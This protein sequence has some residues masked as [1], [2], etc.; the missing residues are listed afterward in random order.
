MKTQNSFH[1]FAKGRKATNT[2][3][4]M[5]DMEGRIV[6]T[7]SGLAEMGKNHFKT[8]YKVDQRVNIVDIVWL[9]L[10]YPSF[11]N[12]KN[13]RDLYMEVNKAELKETLSNFQKDKS[14]G[15]DGWSIEFYL[16]FYELIGVDLLQVVEES[17]RNG[18]M[19]LPFNTTFLD[20]IPKKDEPISLRTFDR[21]HYAIVFTKLCKN[22]L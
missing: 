12:E 4:D 15:P 22:Y 10:F 17:R 11:V 21:L 8:L 13:N 16:G 9:A 2:I 14:P 20:L 6:S 5:K 18:T 19:H 3:W 1:A 7:F